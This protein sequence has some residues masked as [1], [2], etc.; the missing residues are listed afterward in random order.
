L[1]HDTFNLSSGRVDSLGAVAD[2]LVGLAPG[3]SWSATGEEGDIET[4][5]SEERGPVDISR[6]ESLGFSPRYSLEE[7][8]RDTVSWVRTLHDAGIRFE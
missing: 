3:F 6:V 7:G 5:P 1:H 4:I 8:L 2:I